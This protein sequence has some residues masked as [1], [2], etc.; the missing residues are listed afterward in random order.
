M[1]ELIIFDWDGTLMDS[2]ARIVAS[3][4]KA[5]ADIDLPV[6]SVQRARNIIGLNFEDSM[7]Q[8]FGEV[9]TQ[10]TAKY[11][12][13]YRH[14]FYHPKAYEMPF[15][16]GVVDG[17]Q[18]LDTE[19]KLLA[20]ATGKGRRGLAPLLTEHQLE[21]LFITTRCADEAFGKPN[22]QMLLDILEFTGQTADKALMIGD[23][24]Y[25]LQMANNAK[26]ASVAVNYGMH[27]ATELVK[28][29][30]VAMFSSFPELTDWLLSQA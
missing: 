3:L 14:H 15:F 8:L 11:V 1:Y 6:P 23:T 2:S 5:A 29:N 21:D 24:S 9:S 16:E 28:H 12:D 22:P 19:G 18:R 20:V 10:Q 27:R 30:P 13:R 4:R 17:L 7:R 25:D 26:M